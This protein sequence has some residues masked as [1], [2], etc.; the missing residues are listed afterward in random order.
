MK[1]RLFLLF[2]LAA[3]GGWGLGEAAWGLSLQEHSFAWPDW[4]R[5][6]F[7]LAGAVGGS[8]FC[9]AAAAYLRLGL[10]MEWL[11]CLRLGSL[12]LLPG[13][14]GPAWKLFCR[15]LLP[16][17]HDLA[18]RSLQVF[19]AALVISGLALSLLALLAQAARGRLLTRFSP[20]SAALR[21]GACLW[22]FYLLSGA[23]PWG[24][25]NTGD[26]PHYLLMAR[27]L[28]FDHDLDLANN[29]KQAEW[30][31]F[32]DRPDLAPQYPAR[33]D[34]SLYSEHKPL[35]P[36]L[37]APLFPALGPMAGLWVSTLIGALT[38]ALLLGLC[39]QAGLG[40]VAALA[41]FALISLNAAG[42]TYAAAFFPD[43]L[44]GLLLLVGSA[45]VARRLPLLW[46]LLAAAAMAWTNARFYPAAAA[47]VFLFFIQKEQRPWQR[48]AS[49]LIPG[50]SFALA[51]WINRQQF[52]SADPS[53]AYQSIHKSLGDLF[54][55]PEIPRQAL[56][57]W[58]DQEYG[59]LFWAPAFAWALA[60]L[61]QKPGK[62][63]AAWALPALAYYLPVAAYWDWTGVMAPDRYLAPLLPLLALAL[64]LQLPAWR[65]WKSFLVALAL[66]LALGLAMQVLPWLNYS[67]MD[68]QNL[69]LKA[70]Q[71]KL[72]LTLTAIF[73]SFII[74]NLRNGLWAL[75]LLLGLAWLRKGMHEA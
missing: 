57:Q 2:L 64:A 43:A 40:S 19:W 42:W 69:L 62:S 25:R 46:G 16:P 22:I 28:A 17:P 66:S 38:S 53:A 63:W 1:L 58:L 23:W 68:G 39:L 65:L 6:G 18:L 5:S 47:L 14:A 52:G 11:D 51:F 56:G 41:A 15:P 72:G 36:L 34:G 20:K 24:W 44:G 10:E 48:L 13:L 50:L 59:M 27:S 3:L 26:Q 73:P 30:R 74:F 67:K 9:L 35:L 55:V 32:Y 71:A 45:A 4:E 12:A 70:L 49:L 54:P 75:G 29:Y 21:L 37:A 7:W 8:G 31:A 60:A 33:P 61:I